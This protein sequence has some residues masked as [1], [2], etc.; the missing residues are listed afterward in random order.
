MKASNK[1]EI[2]VELIVTE[3]MRAEHKL[4]RRGH[5]HFLGEP[6]ESHEVGEVDLGDITE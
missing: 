1:V 5:E 4:R 3:K 6:V 2:V